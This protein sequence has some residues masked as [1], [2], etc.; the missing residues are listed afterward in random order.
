MHGCSS[1]GHVVRRRRL[2]E[3]LRCAS[4]RPAWRAL[5]LAAGTTTSPA[6]WL[7]ATYFCQLTAFRPTTARATLAVRFRR[8]VSSANARTARRK[9][10]AYGVAPTKRSIPQALSRPLSFLHTCAVRMAAEARS[11]RYLGL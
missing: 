7:A 10:D 4:E 3:A 2:L 8:R 1:R 9:N 5:L 6:H 11:T